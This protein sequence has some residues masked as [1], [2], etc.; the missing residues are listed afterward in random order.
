MIEDENHPEWQA[1]ELAIGQQVANVF[2]AEGLTS[3]AIEIAQELCDSATKKAR[4]H[5][6]RFPD[7]VVCYFLPSRVVRVYDR[8]A[9]HARKQTYIVRLTRDYPQMDAQEIALAFKRAWPDYR[10]HVEDLRASLKGPVQF[11]EEKKP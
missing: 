5:G 11:P 4:E 2:A 10:P 1:V 3:K 8:D 9:D 6:L 7:M